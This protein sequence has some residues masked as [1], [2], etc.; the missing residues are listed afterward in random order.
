MTK[1]MELFIRQLSPIIKMAYRKFIIVYVKLLLS[2]GTGI[3]PVRLNIRKKEMKRNFP[4]T[5]E[6]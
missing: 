1:F 6:H 5:S 2:K 3:I 4:P